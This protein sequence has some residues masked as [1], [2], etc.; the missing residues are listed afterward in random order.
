MKPTLTILTIFLAI[1]CTPGLSAGGDDGALD[2]ASREYFEAFIQGIYAIHDEQLIPVE[3]FTGVVVRVLDEQTILLNQMVLALYLGN[4][5]PKNGVL[6]KTQDTSG[7]HQGQSV[8][9]VCVP[10]GQFRYETK[11]GATGLISGYQTVSEPSHE[12]Y[13]DYL[14][15]G[16]PPEA[17]S[18]DDYEV[19]RAEPVPD[20]PEPGTK[21]YFDR[22]I[23]GRFR[24][25]DGKIE[26]RGGFHGISFPPAAPTQVEGKVVTIDSDRIVLSKQVKKKSGYLASEL[27]AVVSGMPTGGIAIG[28]EVAFSNM[29][30]EGKAICTLSS[31]MRKSVTAYRPAT[32]QEMSTPSS[33]TFSQYLMAYNGDRS[34][35]P[36]LDI[37]DVEIKKTTSSYRD[38]LRQRLATN[39]RPAP[40]AGTR[41]YYDTK[42]KGQYCLVDGK[43][44]KVPSSGFSRRLPGRLSSLGWIKGTVS[45][46]RDDGKVT[47]K[48]GHK[49]ASGAQQWREVIVTPKQISSVKVGQEIE[50]FLI[51][52]KDISASE[53]PG[54][55][56]TRTYVEVETISF[57]EYMSVY[58]TESKQGGTSE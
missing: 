44:K 51:R 28:S 6:I 55:K 5:R 48:M 32:Q 33:I 1:L 34:E 2:P 26:H 42:I 23:S 10:Q 12:E 56:P 52:G 11:T 13:L 38:Q 7:L 27:S 45:S 31:D 37:V 49:T 58:R 8:A 40:K 25:I 19:V 41:A 43:M 9:L 3:R 15:K 39:I 50:A 29:I 18:F 24:L 14:G 4:T 17:A 36:T 20:D 22:Y 21:E 16:L 35:N 54:H 47:V 57:D 53:E 30:R 46:I